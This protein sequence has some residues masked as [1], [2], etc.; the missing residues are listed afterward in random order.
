MAFP[1]LQD[2]CASGRRHNIQWRFGDRV[3]IEPKNDEGGTVLDSVLD[4]ASVAKFGA[5]A[6]S[7]QQKDYRR[8]TGQRVERCIMDNFQNDPTSE[9]LWFWSTQDYCA[10]GTVCTPEVSSPLAWRHSQS[11]KLMVYAYMVLSGRWRQP[12]LMHV[13]FALIHLPLAP[14][15]DVS[16]AMASHSTSADLFSIIYDF[17][18]AVT[19]PCVRQL[20]TTATVPLR[21]RPLKC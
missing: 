12:G 19:P 15:P 6:C 7:Q 5:L 11:V 2:Q 8:C 17:T 21:E 10:G 4:E 16:P 3:I 14:C 20:L 1:S 9:G 13:A 18:V